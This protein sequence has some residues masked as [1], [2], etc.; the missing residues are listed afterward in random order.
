MMCTNHR[1]ADRGR[2]AKGKNEAA[3]TPEEPKLPE[4]HR[5]SKA[6][7][8]G[9]IQGKQELLNKDQRNSNTLAPHWDRLLRT[10]SVAAAATAGRF[11]MTTRRNERLNVKAKVLS[12]GLPTH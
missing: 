1:P 3:D 4:R 7:D 12:P 2:K 6:V 8:C 10:P 11:G 9:G 5:S